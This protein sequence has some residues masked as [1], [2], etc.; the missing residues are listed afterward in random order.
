[1][2]QKFVDTIIVSTCLYFME[3]QFIH[4]TI[5]IVY[6]GAPT[7]LPNTPSK[8]FWTFYLTPSL[9]THPSNFLWHPPQIVYSTLFP[10]L[11]VGI[12]NEVS[13]KNYF[14]IFSHYCEIKICFRFKESRE[15]DQNLWF[16]VLDFDR[17]YHKLS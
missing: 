1:M 7:L 16:N 11:K 5:G 2:F 12:T 6:N 15:F 3:K 14:N 9:F 8:L 17:T 4:F 10:R 13:I